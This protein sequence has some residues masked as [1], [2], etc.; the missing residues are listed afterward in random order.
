M[1][2]SVSPEKITAIS[3]QLDQRYQ[4]F[5]EEVR[6]GKRD[7]T[8]NHFMSNFPPFAAGYNDELFRDT[9]GDRA[10]VDYVASLP[11][12]NPNEKLAISPRKQQTTGLGFLE[13]RDW[14][15]QDAGVSTAQVDAILQ[16]LYG[17]I[18]EFTTL[19]AAVQRTSSLYRQLETTCIP[20]MARMLAL[21]YTENDVEVPGKWR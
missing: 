7:E 10:I 12:H 6:A 3:A 14:A 4:T 2:R 18:E 16:Q 8:T 19:E 21:D 17:S 1:A 13:D 20:V 11:G 15:M 5:L 9:I